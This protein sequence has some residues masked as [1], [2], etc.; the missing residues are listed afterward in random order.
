MESEPSLTPNSAVDHVRRES[1]TPFS[2]RSALHALLGLSDIEERHVNYARTIPPVELRYPP[3]PLPDQPWPLP[4]A[5]QETDPP[6]FDE[7]SAHHPG[8]SAGPPVP[9]ASPPRPVAEQAMV[10]P[11]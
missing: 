11:G 5:W 2:Y 7:A 8:R 9:T 6:G 10:L 3:Q 4:Q 1:A